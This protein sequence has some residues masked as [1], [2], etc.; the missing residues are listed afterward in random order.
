MRKI[1]I[2]LLMALTMVSNGPKYIVDAETGEVV[3]VREDKPV[4]HGAIKAND[5]IMGKKDSRVVFVWYIDMQCPACAQMLPVVNSLYQ[6]YGDKV[7]FVT[8]HLTLKGHD[9]ARP[10]AIAVEAA[11]EQGYFWEMIT[12]LPTETIE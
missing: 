8:R 9:Y 1:F 10:A 2:V 7:A 11:A 5:H 6:K 4:K 3:K 12:E